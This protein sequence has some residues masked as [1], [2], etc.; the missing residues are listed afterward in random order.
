MMNNNIQYIDTAQIPAAEGG[1]GAQN[2]S[3]GYDWSRPSLCRPQEIPS[4]DF[5]LVA[6]KFGQ[7]VMIE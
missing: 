6:I 4:F 3:A 5:R 7:R 2:D 1:G